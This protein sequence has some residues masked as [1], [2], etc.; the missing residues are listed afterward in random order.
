MLIQFK[1]KIHKNSL[2]EQYPLFNKIA[3]ICVVPQIMSKWER[4]IESYLVQE[5]WLF[6]VIHKKI[7][8]KVFEVSRK[9]EIPVS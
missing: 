4:E 3:C 5:W 9:P 8:E 1:S 7:H 2:S 6:N